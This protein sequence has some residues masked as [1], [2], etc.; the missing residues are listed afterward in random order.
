[1]N[2]FELENYNDEENSEET[3]T[4]LVNKYEFDLKENNNFI[5]AQ[6][7][8]TDYN[9]LNFFLIDN[10]NKLN[11]I[12]NKK[13]IFYN[14][15]CDLLNKHLTIADI[16]L[17]NIDE[18]FIINLSN[19]T[20]IMTNYNELMKNNYNDW[21][22]NFYNQTVY[23]L[24]KDI[25]TI[26]NKLEKFQ[27][28]FIHII[29]NLIKNKEDIKNKKICS[30]CY[31]NEINMCAVPCGHTCCSKC[32]ILSRTNTNNNNKCLNCRN[33]IENYIKLYFSI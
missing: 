33:Q 9:K 21:V 4:N 17:K 5:N 24:E 25:K 32:V 27:Q 19:S 2:Y 12:R 6:L 13:E 28:L 22:N 29:N 16:C 26:E 1:M 31:E 14:Y 23:K 7:I 11:D 20:D 30:I 10:K 18:N 8:L 3:F 15:Q